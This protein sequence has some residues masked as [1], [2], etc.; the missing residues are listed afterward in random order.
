MQ[1]ILMPPSKVHDHDSTSL[2]TKEPAQETDL[3]I[4]K[5]RKTDFINSVLIE[6]SG[7]NV[8]TPSLSSFPKAKGILS[9]LFTAQ[10]T[11]KKYKLQYLER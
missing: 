7:L 11:A 8:L 2:L 9:C 10:T 3:K 4:P 5:H 6:I 1:T